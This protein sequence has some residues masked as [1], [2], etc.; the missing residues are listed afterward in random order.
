MGF[1]WLVDSD[2]VGNDDGSGKISFYLDVI[3]LR[4]EAIEILADFYAEVWL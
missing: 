3:F 4:V 1:E 2:F